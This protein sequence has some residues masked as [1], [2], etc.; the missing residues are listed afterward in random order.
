MQNNIV[1]RVVVFDGLLN[2]DDINET[3]LLSKI[4]S[5]YGEHDVDRTYVIQDEGLN[6]ELGCLLDNCT[7]LDMTNVHYALVVKG[8]Q[9][10]LKQSTRIMVSDQMEVQ[11]GIWVW[12]FMNNPMKKS[13]GWETDENY[14]HRLLLVAE[15]ARPRVDD[16]TLYM[17]LNTMWKCKYFSHTIWSDASIKDMERMIVET[18]NRLM[19]PC[20]EVV[21][22]W[23]KH[24][25]QVKSKNPIERLFRPILI[26]NPIEIYAI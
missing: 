13:D 10:F 12:D 9:K 25:N 4:N 8:M 7:T 19:F 23:A 5:V 24:Y 22:D 2:A 11:Q 18:I 14:V 21:I 26:D 6:L 1:Y 3:K 15:Q 20:D 17:L 16:Q